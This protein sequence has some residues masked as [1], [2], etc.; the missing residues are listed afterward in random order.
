MAKL[1]YNEETKIISF[2]VPVSKIPIIKK[3][4]NKLLFEF[5][6]LVDNER[7]IIEFPKSLFKKNNSLDKELPKYTE[8]YNFENKCDCFIDASGFIRRGK[9]KCNKTK[10]QHKF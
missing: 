9:I 5:K 8:Y 10:M 4:V 3:S 1:K 6:I 2:R 7:Q